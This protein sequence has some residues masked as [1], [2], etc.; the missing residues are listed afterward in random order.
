MTA[1]FDRGTLGKAVRL[2][3]GGL[4]IPARVARSGIQEYIRDGK[5]VYEYRPPE[6]VFAPESLASLE[7]AAVTI[8]HTSGMVTP[9]NWQGTAKGFVRRITGRE[10]VDGD[11]FITANLAVLSADALKEITDT[12]ALT[13]CSCGYDAEVINEPGITPDGR[14]YD[15]IQRNIRYNHVALLPPNTARAGVN[16]RLLL[17][18]REM[19]IKFDG[20]DFDTAKPEDLGALQATLSGFEVKFS[21]AQKSLGE[22]Q[23][24]LV[25]ADARNT[26]LIAELPGKI[27]TEL[28]FRDRIRPVLG[29]EYKFDGKSRREVQVDAIKAISPTFDAKDQT[30]A[31]VEA[32]LSVLLDTRSTS[33][34]GFR[35]DATDAAPSSADQMMAAHRKRMHGLYDSKL[36]GE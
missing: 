13:E 12:K 3:G 32:Y 16:A 5:T 22:A 9:E 25:K 33:E 1:Y 24:R 23:A 34:E 11:E 36:G 20:K 31:Y 30:D 7:S 17:D 19:A 14:R 15:S 21:E 4:G 8:G 29:K 10:T 28:K 2:P 18:K 35:A 26:E 6:E 27:E